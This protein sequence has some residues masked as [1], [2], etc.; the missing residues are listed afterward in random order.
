[1]LAS[2][3]AAT[4]AVDVSESLIATARSEDPCSDSTYVV[5]TSP[6]TSD[7]FDLVSCMG[8]LVCVL[9]D[10]QFQELVHG[11]AR[12]VAPGG[13][14]LLRETLSWGAP[15]TVELAEYTARYR[16]PLDYLQPL[17]QDGIQ[18]VHDEHLVTWSETDARSNHLW[19]LE[20]PLAA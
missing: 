17:A 1:L 2:N 7:Q 18:L 20:R 11:L 13:T 9:E 16:T 3:C 14:L 15:Q 6:P 8:V 10:T 19:V 12:C 5:G 4:L